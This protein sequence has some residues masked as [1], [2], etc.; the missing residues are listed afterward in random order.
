[1]ATEQDAIH[2]WFELTY[3]NY[4]V[5]PRS[6]L[7]S[8]P[9]DLQVKLVDALRAIEHHIAPASF[10]S[11]GT[12]KVYLKNDRGRFMHDPLADYQRGRRIV[13]REEL[14]SYSRTES[15]T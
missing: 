15:A 8:L 13:T 5:L 6:V 1:M 9:D 10:P 11:R 7:Q 3:A 12:Y 14:I 2:N 4:L